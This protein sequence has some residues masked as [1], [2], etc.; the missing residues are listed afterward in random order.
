MGTKIIF[1]VRNEKIEIGGVPQAM[2]AKSHSSVQGCSG[3][4]LK[5]RFS[6]IF[7]MEVSMRIV[8]S[9]WTLNTAKWHFC[10]CGETFEFSLFQVYGNLEVHIGGCHIASGRPHCRFSADPDACS[11]PDA[12]HPTKKLQRS[13]NL[14]KIMM[15]DMGRLPHCT[16]TLGKSV[17]G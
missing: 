9:N 15:G 10:E 1:S 8:A 12:L 16:P 2:K 4:P 11:A 3:K 17:A 6:A 14:L 7:Y 13:P 5:H